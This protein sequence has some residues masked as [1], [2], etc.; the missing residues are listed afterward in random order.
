[1]GLVFVVAAITAA[2][3]LEMRE[4]RHDRGSAHFRPFAENAEQAF[5]GDYLEQSPEHQRALDPKGGPPVFEPTDI[6][7]GHY[8]LDDDGV[9]EL[10]LYFN[11]LYHCRRGGCAVILF[12]GGEGRWYEIGRASVRDIWVGEE[13]HGGHRLIYS[14]TGRGLR[15]TG[16]KY[17]SYCAGFPAE[18]Q[19]DNNECSCCR[20]YAREK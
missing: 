3:A 14:S 17:E 6:W 13:K 9:D 8:D 11:S 20:V 18:W 15:W 19:R 1:L 12:K 7:V 2:S 10:I 5:I 16:A 4:W